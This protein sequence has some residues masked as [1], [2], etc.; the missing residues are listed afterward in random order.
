MPIKTTVMNSKGVLGWQQ[1]GRPN[2]IRRNTARP[3]GLPKKAQLAWL[4]FFGY[5]GNGWDLLFFT[6]WWRLY[7]GWWIILQ[8]QFEGSLPSSPG[9][10]SSAP[11]RDCG[12]RQG[13]GG[14]GRRKVARKVTACQQFFSVKAIGGWPNFKYEK[15]IGKP[16]ERSRTRNYLV[17]REGVN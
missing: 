8:D 1:S 16:L 7:L 13:K 12:G 14:C 6:L 17:L 4:F 3:V 15:H 11:Q 2:L 10:D 9:G 5:S